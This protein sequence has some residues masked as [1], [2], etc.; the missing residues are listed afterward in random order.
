[1]SRGTSTA[2]ASCA[3][4]AVSHGTN[5]QAGKRAVSA[6]INEVRRLTDVDV[7]QAFV[8]V[9]EPRASALLRGLSDENQSSVLVPLLISRGVHVTEDLTE[10]AALRPATRVAAALGPHKSLAQVIEHRLVQAGWLP[11]EPVILAGA[12][13]RLRQGTQDCHQ[14]AALL[15]DRLGVAVS[16]AFVAAAEPALEQAVAAARAA[17]PHHRVVVASYLL[18]PGY[19]QSLIE[20]CGTDLVSGALLETDGPVPGELVDLVLQRFAAARA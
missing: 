2:T 20:R 6:L 4:I 15:A 17:A 3:L 11:G 10:A 7:Y 1:M 12:G 18:A 8:D 9:Q 14:A 13:T 16:V 5:D 19:F